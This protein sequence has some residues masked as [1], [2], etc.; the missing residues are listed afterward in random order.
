MNSKESWMPWILRP[1]SNLDRIFKSRNLKGQFVFGDL[2]EF[3]GFFDA[4]KSPFWPENL[5]IMLV[6]NYFLKN[7]YCDV[8]EDRYHDPRPLFFP[9]NY[10]ILLNAHFIQGKIFIALKVVVNF[11]V[12]SPLFKFRPC[13]WA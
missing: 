8:L 12:I 11:K 7:S 4:W 2:R 6:C 5:V 10:E 13:K 1:I 3:N 9:V